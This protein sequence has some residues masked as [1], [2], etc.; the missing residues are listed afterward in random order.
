MNSREEGEK[1]APLFFYVPRTIFT[2][3]PSNEA[4]FIGWTERGNY[5]G[6]ASWVVLTYLRLRE[7]QVPVEFVSDIPD[8]GIVITHARVLR[9][10]MPKIPRSVL[11]VCIEGDRGRD[12]YAMVHV[13]QNPVQECTGAPWRRV[14]VPY[15]T[16]PGLIPRRPQ[17]GDRFET[18]AFFGNEFNLAPELRGKAWADMLEKLGLR[19]DPRLSHED[20]YDYS[21]V[22]AVLAVRS[23]RGHWNELWKP[24]NKLFNAWSAGT[25]PIVAPE[26]AMV[27]HGRDRVDC[28]ICA[29]VDSVVACL[30]EL[31][32][33]QDL[34]RQL[35]CNGRERAAAFQS[36]AIT[37]LWRRLIAEILVP[38]FD[39]LSRDRGKWSLR[40]V[41]SAVTYWLDWGDR[42]GRYLRGKVAARLRGEAF[43]GY[44]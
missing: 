2:D 22:D 3:V 34:R 13:V 7:A 40:R 30:H 9:E 27:S 8:C 23:F 33:S 42:Y 29:S 37:D 12:A 43:R 21:E 18:L 20:W 16:Q 11:L 39:E 41:E 38:T 1:H 14:Y 25:I 24:A 31:V 15:W 35:R 32:A 4:D 19:W 5:H 44:V 17:R 36:D 28:M 6:V 26:S 10:A